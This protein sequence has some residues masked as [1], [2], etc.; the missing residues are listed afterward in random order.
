M[1]KD[2]DG[3]VRYQKSWKMESRVASDECPEGARAQFFQSLSTRWTFKRCSSTF[4]C[5]IN[6]KRMLK[7]IFQNLVCSTYFTYFNLYTLL[8][9]IE[10]WNTVNKQQK[11]SLVFLPSFIQIYADSHWLI[12]FVM[13]MSYP[14]QQEWGF[15]RIS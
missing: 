2:I 8:N 4:V 10:L 7:H 5:S 9:H 11:L 13:Q 6:V 1:L 12:L 14:L 15:P 3:W